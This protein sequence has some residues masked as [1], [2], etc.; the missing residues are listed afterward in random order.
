ME[1]DINS[2]VTA[3]QNGHK[4][5]LEAVVSYAQGYVYNLALKMLQNPMDA[6]D[7]TQ[8]ILIK[9]ITHLGQF[10]GESAFS[11]WMYR[12]ASNTLLN[13]YQRDREKRHITFAELS[14]RLEASLTQ[15][16]RNVEDD[17]EHTELAEEV[18]RNCTLG[19]L[20]CLGPEDRLALILGEI[21]QVSSE[22]GAGIMGIGSSAYR[23]RLSRARQNLVAFV[24]GQCGIVNPENPCRCHKHVQNKIQAGQL[25]PENLRYGQP[26]TAES[27]SS[28][29]RA[30]QAALDATTRTQALLRSHPNY[31][32]NLNCHAMIERLFLSDDSDR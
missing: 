15:Y 17:Y 11:T 18:R 4:A 6:E 31:H 26:H 10:R 30:H 19:M 22:E 24:S 29:E 23:K 7:A 32:S 21:L 3:A 20:M 27:L 5:A 16:E 25:D 9:L 14:L 1:Q 12:M 28:A 8:E 2:L 13:I